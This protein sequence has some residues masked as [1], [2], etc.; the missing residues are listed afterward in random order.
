MACSAQSRNC[1]TRE[2]RT[3]EPAGT[4]APKAHTVR[5]LR[6]PPPNRSRFS[7]LLI[8]RFIANQSSSRSRGSGTLYW[9]SK[10]G[11]QIPLI[12]SQKTDL[13]VITDWN[14]PD[15]GGLELCKHIPGDFPDCCCHLILLTGNSNKELETMMILLLTL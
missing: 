5:D 2:F 14:M 10:N 6:T 9:F 12:C 15:R 4:P 1:D 8:P 13:L 7:R 11:R 3:A